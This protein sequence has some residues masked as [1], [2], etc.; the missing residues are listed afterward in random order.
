LVGQDTYLAGRGEQEPGLGHHLFLVR[1]QLC[2]GRT[3]RLRY[4][5][6]TV[7]VEDRRPGFDAA[8]DEFGAT[9][10]QAGRLDHQA[11]LHSVGKSGIV[12]AA[13]AGHRQIGGRTS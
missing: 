7:I 13:Y 9:G 4:H 2:L 6:D 5:R 8:G 10:T 11:R 3:H 1:I 12:F